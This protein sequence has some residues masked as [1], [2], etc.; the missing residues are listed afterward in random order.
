MQR[1]APVISKASFVGNRRWTT[2][3][4]H[5]WLKHDRDRNSSH[6]THGQLIVHYDVNATNRLITWFLSIDDKFSLIR[7]PNFIGVPEANTLAWLTE[8]L[9]RCQMCGCRRAL[10]QALYSEGFVNILSPDCRGAARTLFGV[11]SGVGI[12]EFLQ[13][14]F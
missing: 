6:R 1:F 10:F 13:I 4:W 8:M 11:G 14:I 7:K 12:E 5:I 2:R 9:S 3:S